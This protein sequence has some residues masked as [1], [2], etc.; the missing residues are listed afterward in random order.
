MTSSSFKQYYQG[1]LMVC[2]AFITGA[3]VFSGIVLFVTSMNYE[4]VTTPGQTN[5]LAILVPFFAV[6]CVLAGNALYKKKIMKTK[7][8][9]TFDEKLNAFKL[10]T[11]IRYFLTDAPALLASITYFLTGEKKILIVTGA[12]ICLMLYRLPNKKRLINA[13]DVSPAEAAVITNS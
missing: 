1:L 13:L 10:A 3:T 5:M 4:P 12:L 11:F 8:L 6:V 2:I 9:S 7:E